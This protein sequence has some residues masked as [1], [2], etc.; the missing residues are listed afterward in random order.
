MTKDWSPDD[1]ELAS[2]RAPHELNA[3]LRWHKAKVPSQEIMKLLRLK[4]TQLLAKIEEGTRAEHEAEVRG[5]PV[6]EALMPK[7]EDAD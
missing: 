2:T 5:L 3:V 6:H 7:E 1:P 4:G